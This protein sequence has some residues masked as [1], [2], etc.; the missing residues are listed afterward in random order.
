MSPM[1][2]ALRMDGGHRVHM[3]Q[4]GATPGIVSGKTLTTM[5]LEIK[6]QH[7]DSSIIIPF[8]GSHL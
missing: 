3:E 5:T 6:M 4:V 8:L 2:L 1:V 7:I